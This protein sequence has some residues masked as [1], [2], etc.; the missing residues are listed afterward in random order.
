MFLKSLIKEDF[1]KN[2]AN[3]SIF[4]LSCFQCHLMNNVFLKINNK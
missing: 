3:M 4:I 1:P 2:K